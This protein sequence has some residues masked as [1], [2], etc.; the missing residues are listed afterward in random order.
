MLMKLAMWGAFHLAEAGGRFGVRIAPEA[1]LRAPNVAAGTLSIAVVGAA[2]GLL[3]SPW[4]GALSAAL[5]AFDPNVIAINRIGKEDTF[6]VLFFFL[7]IW[8]YE[9]AKRIGERDVAAARPWYTAAGAAFGLMLAS[10]Y[11]PHLL[12]LYALFNVIYQRDAGQNRP[13]QPRY[14]AAMAAAFVAAN[15]AILSPATWSYCLAYVQGHH[16]A[17][18][19]QFFAGRLYVTDVP[20]S[21]AGVPF[22]Y[23]AQMIATK[24][25][26]AVLAAAG[27]GMIPMLRARHER[28]VTWLRVMV[29]FLLIGYSVAAAKFQRYGLPLLILVDIVAALGI[30]RAVEWVMTVQARQPLKWA[31]AATMCAGVVMAPLLASAAVR[32]FYSAHQNMLGARLAPPVTMFPEEAYDY[33]V[34][35]AV[36][37]IARRA[38][39]GAS[40]ISDASGVVSH[41]VATSGRRDLQVLTL[42]QSGL[43]HHGEQWVLVQDD[44]LSFENMASVAALRATQAWRQYTLMNTAVLQIYQLRN[45]PVLAARRPPALA[46]RAGS[47]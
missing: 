33:G 19:G 38:A 42:S 23:Y 22:T 21:L 31:A 16:L 27:I 30:V 37:D 3:L 39:P 28:G 47:S 20:V 43:S 12:G 46:S 8:C 1:A 18:H 36:A 4:A 34:R 24:V 40:V 29:V 35:E 2:V 5:V 15:F 45:E 44:H 41:Y 11:M 13:D 26:S 6:L 9:R 32:P 10:K 17:H 7:A 25:P 14:Y